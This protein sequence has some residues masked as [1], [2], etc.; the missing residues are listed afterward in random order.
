M[1]KIEKN[2]Y[3]FS[4]IIEAM[5]YV[6][7]LYHAVNIKP[8]T[9]KEIHA[10][11]LPDIL[12]KLKIDSIEPHLLLKGK[13]LVASLLGSPSYYFITCKGRHGSNNVDISI[14]KILTKLHEQ[15]ISLRDIG[16]CD[17]I[18]RFK[19]PYVIQQIL[20]NKKPDKNDAIIYSI[21]KTA[22]EVEITLDI[23]DWDIYLNTSKIQKYIITYD[24]NI[25]MMLPYGK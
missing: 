1:L 17:T 21:R 20:K 9:I 3:S 13:T 14:K 4:F 12:E 23:F 15:Q 8:E 24:T 19:I 6:S 7:G 2:E 18:H 22:V 10:R 5:F 11:I 16:N 25:S